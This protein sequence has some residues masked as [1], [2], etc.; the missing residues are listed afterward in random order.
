MREA[1][2]MSAT[3]KE[4]LDDLTAYREKVKEVADN[5]QE[6]QFGPPK[7]EQKTQVL[8]TYGDAGLAAAAGVGE[9]GL[10]KTKALGWQLFSYL[11][12]TN[13]EKAQ[14]KAKRANRKADRTLTEG[15]E[16]AKEIVEKLPTH[17]P[18]LSFQAAARFFKN[19]DENIGKIEALLTREK[20]PFCS[21][22]PESDMSELRMLIKHSQEDAQHDASQVKK[23]QWPHLKRDFWDN[24]ETA[25]SQKFETLGNDISN[26]FKKLLRTK[27]EVDKAKEAIKKGGFPTAALD[28]LK[29]SN[30]YL[31]TNRTLGD[32]RKAVSDLETKLHNETDYIKPKRK[33]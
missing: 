26:W 33:K 13:T 6:L 11:P 32:E 29:T 28:Q 12:G 8:G 31:P 3:P 22:D 20:P 4:I 5:I 2:R 27:K 1:D 16:E 9:A 17:T 25:I 24:V 23:N 10:E 18:D 14:R 7:I 15:L 19:V 30:P 21:E